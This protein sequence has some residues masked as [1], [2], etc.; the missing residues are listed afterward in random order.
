MS[1]KRINRMGEKII[2]GPL[3]AEVLVYCKVLV[4]CLLFVF[5]LSAIFVFPFHVSDLS[6][7]L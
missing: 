6:D 2:I 1:L 3:G 4:N 5:G 7:G